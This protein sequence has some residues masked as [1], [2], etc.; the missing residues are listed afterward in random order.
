MSGPY[1]LA[2]TISARLAQGAGAS[3][4]SELQRATAGLSVPIAVQLDPKALAALGQ[5]GTAA[6]SAKT[7]VDGLRTAVQSTSRALDR[8]ATAATKAAAAAGTLTGQTNASTAAAARSAAAFTAAGTSAAGFGGQVGGAGRSLASLLATVGPA[9]NALSRLGAGLSQTRATA[10]ALSGSF[11]S[12][13]GAVREGLQDAIRFDRE[14]VRLGQVSEEPRAA[15]RAL[16]ADVAKLGATLG[17]SSLQLAKTVVDL[18][19]SGLSMGE[20]RTAIEAIGKASLS[21][22]FEGGVKQITELSIAARQFGINSKDLTGALGSVGAVSATTATE[23]SDL[24]AAVTRAGGSA[25][26]AGIKF[27][28]PLGLMAS[29]RSTT[30]ESAESIAT[31]FRTIFARLQRADT[32]AQLAAVGVQLRRTR[33]EAEALGDAT[34]EGEFVGGFEAIRRLSEAT[35]KVRTTDPRF[36]QITEAL[37]G[38]P[39]L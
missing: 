38:Y 4:R 11:G 16:G 5:L 28:E 21:P 23:A 6:T 9:A 36:A 7:C 15:V 30:R 18:R 24:A 34:S 32:V 17:V 12:V 29:V 22:S 35:S 25:A 3:I 2:V 33:Q 39:Q 14:L 8:M 27:N 10:L 13:G 20:T 26:A 31:G 1:N 37:G 19:Q